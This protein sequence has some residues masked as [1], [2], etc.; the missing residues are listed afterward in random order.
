MANELFEVRNGKLYFNFHEGQ[1]RAWDSSARFTFVLA[2]TQSGKTSFGP[3]WLWR[4]IQQTADPAGGTNDYIAVTAS[5]DLFKLKL[6]P[7]LRAAFEYTLQWG[8]YWPSDRVIEL[9]DPKTGKFWAVHADDRMWGR[10]VLRSAASGGGL[11]S[12]SAKAAFLDECG[13][14]SFTIETWEAILRR[15]SLSQG[16]VGAFT[17]P[18]NL[19]W[20]KTEVWDQWNAGNK[21][22]N[23]IN[24]PS[25][26]NPLF[27]RA[28]YERAK[29]T[30][31]AHRFAMF[32]D[33][34]LSR[35]A[36]LIYDC[37]DEEIHLVDDFPI[38]KEWPRYGGLDFGAVNT[39]KL[40][41]AEDVA[42]GRYYVYRENL[43]GGLSTREHA[44][45]IIEHVR[46]ENHI[47]WWGGAPSEEQQRMDYH[48]EG[49][50]VMRPN[51]SDVESGID[52]VT[53]LFKTKRLF[54]F[55]SLTGMRDEL[56]S[57]KRKIDEYGNPTEEI[58]EKRKYHRLDAL[59][60]LAIGLMDGGV[61]T[62]PP[63]F[64]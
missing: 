31:P 52:R 10:I 8:R 12:M 4:E 28:E 15:L 21:D 44:S 33:G 40:W 29:A 14:D 41:I 60:Y 48:T 32:Y 25:Y 30:M 42:R 50:Y 7:E 2:G 26:F 45:E 11:E 61:T 13:Q 27:N 17:T 57:Y 9:K 16:R 24:F 19:G 43:N 46:N 58:A 59:R 3:W 1:L 6:L 53:E 63:I 38:P 18:Y 39:A 23:V 54:V 34:L 56:G 5:F 35:P 22:F 20:I 64:Y 37:F 47:S 55:R 62:G 36:G 51:V 49:V